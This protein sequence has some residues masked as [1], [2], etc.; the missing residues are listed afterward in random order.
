MN[1][2]IQKGFQKLNRIRKTFQYTPYVDRHEEIQRAVEEMEKEDYKTLEKNRRDFFHAADEFFIIDSE[3]LEEV[4]SRFYGF[5]LQESG[6][7]EQA[8]MTPEAMRALDGRGVYV[9]VE[10]DEDHVIIRQDYNGSYGLYLYQKE[11]YFALSNSFYYLLEYLKKKVSLTANEDYVKEFL[12]IPMVPVT[13]TETPICEIQMLERDLEVRIDKSTGT[14]TL[15]KIDYEIASLSL[16]TQEGMDALDHWYL[17]WTKLLRRLARE[18]DQI[19]VDLSGGFDSRLSFLLLLKSGI[20]L[21]KI[22]IK[23][24]QDALHTHAEDY[25]IASS[26]A[27]YFSF[28]LNQEPTPTPNLHYSLKDILNIDF[29]TNFFFHK[30]LYH[31]H[32]RHVSRHFTVSGAGGEAVRY[33][34]KGSTVKFRWKMRQ[35][36]KRYSRRTGKDLAAGERRI[37]SRTFRMIQER[38]HITNPH[39]KKTPAF[40]YREGRTINHFAKSAVCDWFVNTCVLAPLLDPDLGKLILEL[41]DCKDNNLLMAVIY[42]RYCPELLKFP[43]E[44]NRKIKDAAITTA[45]KL[46]EQ[47]PFRGETDLKDGNNSNPEKRGCMETDHENEEVSFV[48]VH[49]DQKAAEAIREKRDNPYVPKDRPD[50]WLKQA[51]FSKEC[52][53]VFTSAYSE[54][55]YY[56]AIWQC[57]KKDYHPMEYCNG[58]L[59]VTKILSDTQNTMAEDFL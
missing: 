34:W 45:K 55:I 3:N 56:E 59:A 8:N 51:F 1:N 13:C 5:S 17:S 40:I 23:S 16:D 47:F 6:I 43:F 28:A 33:Y 38:Y 15:H 29:Y 26:I 10:A 30:E 52:R 4:Q 19:S 39:S 31:K 35:Y 50:A 46:N 58:V 22:R 18:T 37:M 57:Q 54:E 44:G 11:G 21:N 53:E 24:F 2:K 7:Y 36:A 48:F 9:S 27:E 20:D 42:E 41:P 25:K 32:C 14:P 49:E 12:L